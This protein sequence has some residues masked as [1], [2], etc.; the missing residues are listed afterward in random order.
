MSASTGLDYNSNTAFFDSLVGS[1]NKPVLIINKTVEV[2][3]ELILFGWLRLWCKCLLDDIIVVI[4]VYGLNICVICKRKKN[5][6]GNNAINI[7]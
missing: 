4:S 6:I 3:E 7:L 2:G 1:V 5:R